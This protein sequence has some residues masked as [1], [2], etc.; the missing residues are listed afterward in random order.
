MSL[1]DTV[2]AHGRHR[3]QDRIRELKALVADKSMRLQAADRFI[4]QLIREKSDA[5]LDVRNLEQQLACTEGLV[6]KQLQQ[7]QQ[8]RAQA[9]QPARRITARPGNTSPTH[10]P[11]QRAA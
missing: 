11:G 10:I 9:A 6:A 1:L 5:L 4:A 2:R 7:I 8:L 3:A